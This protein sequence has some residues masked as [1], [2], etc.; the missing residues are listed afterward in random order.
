MT[1]NGVGGGGEAVVIQA[2]EPQ[3]AARGC[4]S[5]WPGRAAPASP[6]DSSAT[7]QT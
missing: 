7:S 2:G 3:Q 1:T 4:W 5:Q 6:D